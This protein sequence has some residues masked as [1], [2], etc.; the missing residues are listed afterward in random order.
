VHVSGQPLGSGGVLLSITDNGTGISDE[1]MS[2][3]NW[4]LDNPPMVDVA[5]SRRMGLFVVG[6]LAA[7]HGVRV[8]LRH[9]QPGGLTALIWLP[10]KVAAPQVAPPSGTLRR[11]EVHEYGS[12]PS[13][14]APPLAAASPDAPTASMP[15]FTPAPSPSFTAGV[16]EAPAAPRILATGAGTSAQA[17]LAAQAP[18]DGGWGPDSLLG[19]DPGTVVTPLA[20]DQDQR[21]PIFDSLESEWFRHSGKRLDTMLTRGTETPRWT[22]PADE[23]WRAAQAVASPAAGDITGAGL[24]RRLPGTNLVPGSVRSGGGDES[25]LPV[26]S[27]DAA[28]TRMAGFQRAVR[29]GRAAAPQT[30]EP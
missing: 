10:D 27:P 14:S 5:V 8:R 11:F 26:R 25:D 15:R 6:R 13:L 20:D 2:H 22:S 21:L 16:P 24:P 1:E 7:R 4:R 29:E 30:E 3:A 19:T 17:A 23:G 12:M 9:A 28:R 18:A